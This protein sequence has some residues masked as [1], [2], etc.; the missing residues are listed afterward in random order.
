MFAE[1]FS[2]KAPSQDVEQRVD[3]IISKMSLTDKLELIGGNDRGTKECKAAGFPALRM[4]DGP[5]GTHWWCKNSTAYPALIALAATWDRELSRKM[6]HSLGR[7]C[8]ARGIHILLAP[9]VNIYRSPL[10]GRNFEYLGEDPLLSSQMVVP[11][12]RGLQAQGVAA[13]VKHYA[14]NFQEYDRHGISSDVDERTLREIYL[15]AFKAAI[16]AGGCGAVM[17][18][19]NSVNGIHC[20]EHQYLNNEILKGE[21]A[22]DGLVMS[23][24]VST[25]SAIGAANGGLDLEMPTGQWFNSENLLPAIENGEVTEEVIN[26]KIRRLVRLAVCFGWLD[27]PQQ[28]ESIPMDDSTSSQT[29]LEI[30]R[31]STVLLK[32]EDNVL[33]LDPKKIKTLAIVG[34]NSHPAVIGGGGSAY[35]TPW[36][37]TSILEGIQQ[38]AGEDIEIL[39]SVGVNPDRD[40]AIYA[41]STFL[42]PS[43][44]PGIRVEFFNDGDPIPV[45]TRIDEHI[46]CDWGS[47]APSEN[48]APS[49]FS[50][51]WSGIICPDH[52]GEYTLYTRTTDGA[53]RV[54]LDGNVVIDAWQLENNSNLQATIQM[55]AGRNYNLTIEYKK[56]RYWAQFQFGWEHSAIRK[57]DYEHALENARRADAV[58][59]CTGFTPSLEY[60]GGDRP[61]A[62]PEAVDQ[63]ISDIAELNSRTTVVLAGGGNIDMTNWLNKIQGLLHAWYPGQ[64]GG[65]AIAEIIFGTVNPSG[66]LPA[67]FEARLEDRSSY[68]CYADD[69][70]DKHVALTD[71]IF[72]GYRHSD[73]AAI[74]PL[75]PFGF[76]L[77]YTTFAYEKLS[78]SS[79]SINQNDELT[80]TC[81]ILNTGSRAGREI[82]QLYIRDIHA[83]V[84]RP[85]KELKSFTKIS[86]EPGQRTTVEFRIT[87]QDLAFYD[88]DRATWIAE[89]GKF[90]I[91]I[92]ASCCDIRLQAGFMLT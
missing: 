5:V 82:A 64:D 22:F 54:M 81:D 91:L 30:A 12:I 61:F 1:N 13:T 86:L 80:V 20:S 44:K 76:G 36:H 39:H 4:S 67:T 31:E 79:T 69:D 27:N 49:N 57:A 45:A 51:R 87:S 32:N 8:R 78:L 7:D 68:D 18:A 38:I 89:P 85:I 88:T 41:K 71:G 58:I 62:M 66:K 65:Q 52:S 10:C 33:P 14:L 16:H 34:H 73:R 24:W 6:G 46:N 21:W 53:S 28:D 83:S 15:P 29:A 35:T 75:F 23:D 90:E 9:G 50:V 42:T 60:E 55:E 70:N 17:T 92:G 74:E 47:N 3:T 77:S 2:F 63:F 26:D 72:T 84:P 56:S 37:S 11:Y 59:I 25:Y 19:Y 43:G 40:L 48:V